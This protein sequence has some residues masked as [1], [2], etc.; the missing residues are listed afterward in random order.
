MQDF[1]S[2]NR[3]RAAVVYGVT[4]EHMKFA[5]D[6]LPNAVKTLIY[7]VQLPKTIHTSLILDILN[8][9]F[10]NKGNMKVLQGH[11]DYACINSTY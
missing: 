10:K 6:D 4:V 3:G 7:N 2:L 1:N 9:I 11:N 8:N 5:A